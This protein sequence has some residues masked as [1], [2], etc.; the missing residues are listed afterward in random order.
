MT[1]L[2]YAINGKQKKVNYKSKKILLVPKEDWLIR[3][4]MHEPII[5]QET[6]DIVQQHIRTRT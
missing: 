5:D 3:I 6:F 2:G 1:Y 4:G